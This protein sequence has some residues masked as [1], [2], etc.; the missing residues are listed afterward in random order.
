MMRKSMMPMTNCEPDPEPVA[1]GEEW[2]KDVGS[3][4]FRDAR[5]VSET[6]TTTHDSGCKPFQ[7][8]DMDVWP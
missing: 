4:R 2:V 7:L 1:S 3:Y 8:L 6:L 5:P